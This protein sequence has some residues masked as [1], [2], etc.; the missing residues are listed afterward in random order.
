MNQCQWPIA[1][2]VCKHYPMVKPL[3]PRW[4]KECPPELAIVGEYSDSGDQPMVHTIAAIAHTS[5]TQGSPQN[6]TSLR[7]KHAWTMFDRGKP[8][9]QLIF[10]WPY[11]AFLRAIGSKHPEE[12]SDFV[13]TEKTAHGVITLFWRWDDVNAA[14]KRG[15]GVPGKLKRE[16]GMGQ[17]L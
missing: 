13:T 15:A 4:F 17:Y 11:M 14:M 12:F 3:D 16:M 7:F 5:V 6:N 2:S 1:I 8:V 9:L 10:P